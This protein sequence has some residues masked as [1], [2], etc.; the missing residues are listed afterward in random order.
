MS[1][2]FVEVLG[3][4]HELLRRPPTAQGCALG[5]DSQL[6]PTRNRDGTL[7]SGHN[8]CFMKNIF[9]GHQKLNSKN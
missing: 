8:Q 6:S 7:S 1:Q 2:G 5:V 3:F 9:E 4:L